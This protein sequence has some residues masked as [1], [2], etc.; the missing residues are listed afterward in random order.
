VRNVASLIWRKFKG[1][2]AWLGRCR[3]NWAGCIV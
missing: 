2:W 1:T 3:L